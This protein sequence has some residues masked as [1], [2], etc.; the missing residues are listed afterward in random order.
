[1]I[2]QAEQAKT[3]TPKK[4]SVIY[5]KRLAK[6]LKKRDNLQHAK[7]LDKAAEML[8]YTNY[9]NFLNLETK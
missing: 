6:F 1:M 2:S 4:V 9:K 7:A 5:L 8:G 3:D